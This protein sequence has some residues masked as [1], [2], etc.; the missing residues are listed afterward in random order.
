MNTKYYIF[1]VAVLFV[2]CNQREPEATATPESEEVT[3][4]QLSDV[5][6]NKKV[7]IGAV[8]TRSV[9]ETIQCTGRI[10]IPPTDLVSVHSKMEG[11]IT[12]LK[13]LSSDY[14]QKG[15]L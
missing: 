10:E 4:L 6:A 9:S 5:E 15:T 3:T 13:Y 1:L 14:V 8:Q 2:A 12:Y 11:Q 7:Q